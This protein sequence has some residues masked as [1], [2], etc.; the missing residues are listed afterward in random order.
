METDPNLVIKLLSEQIDRFSPSPA[1][2]SI[3]ISM[4]AGGWGIWGCVTCCLLSL[5]VVFFIARDV[6]EIKQNDRDQ[7]HQ[8]NAIY[9]YAPH[10]RP[11]D[12][13]P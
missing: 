9:Q 6:A 10:L 3:S 7:M 5:V 11:K 2:I 1:K 13:K 8:M 12:K 4:G